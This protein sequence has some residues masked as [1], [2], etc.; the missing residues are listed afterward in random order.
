MRPA[1]PLPPPDPTPHEEPDRVQLPGE[2]PDHPLSSG[3]L[4]T[5]ESLGDLS[6]RERLILQR[7][8]EKLVSYIDEKFT[9]L[10]TQMNKKFEEWTQ[11]IQQQ[12]VS[13][14]IENTTEPETNVSENGHHSD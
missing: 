9:E 1:P 2:A 4:E 7:L 5:S 14:N 3:G 6:E 12:S 10:Q 11:K 8:E 13:R